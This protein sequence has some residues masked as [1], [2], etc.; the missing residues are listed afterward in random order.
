MDAE[1]TFPCACKT[2]DQI[3][4]NIL[5]KVH[6]L[7]KLCPLSLIVYL[8]GDFR[9]KAKPQFLHSPWSEFLTQGKRPRV[10]LSLSG[11]NLRDSM[12]RV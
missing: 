3:V 4:F 7:D 5:K 11:S 12:L 6:S 10:E 9:T 8:E 2:L 1:W